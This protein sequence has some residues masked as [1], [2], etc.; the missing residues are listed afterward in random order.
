MPQELHLS[1]QKVLK[2]LKLL[3]FV[4]FSFFSIL[5]I[6]VKHFL[7]DNNALFDSESWNKRINC[8]FKAWNYLVL[9]RNEK[10]IFTG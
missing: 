6:M 2:V 7:N 3:V 10:Q 9:E 5:N 8:L 4:L 1:T